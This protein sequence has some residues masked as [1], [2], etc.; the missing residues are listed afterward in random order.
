M[1]PTPYS[2]ATVRDSIIM[3]GT[4]IESGAVVQYAIIAENAVIQENAIIGERP[5][6]VDDINRWGVTVI[7]SGA[8]IGKGAKIKAKEMIYNDVKEGEII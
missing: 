2:G 4:V 6:L 7:A 1:N 5:E 3:P 8:T